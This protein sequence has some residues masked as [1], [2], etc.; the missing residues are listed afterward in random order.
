[1]VV[2]S[3]KNNVDAW[4]QIGYLK[5]RGGDSAGAREAFTACIKSG[6]EKAAWAEKAL[7]KLGKEPGTEKK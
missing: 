5:N 6:G 4:L 3:D 2:A 7:K 1:M